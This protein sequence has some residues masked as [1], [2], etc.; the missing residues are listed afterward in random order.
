MYNFYFVYIQ[1]IHSPN[2]YH[3]RCIFSSTGS[4]TAQIIFH[5]YTSLL[6][7]IH[8]QHHSKFKIKTLQKH[9]IEVIIMYN[10]YQ[11]R[12]SSPADL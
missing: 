1:F 6:F 12:Y 4:I 2:H 3:N 10:A 5:P 9:P 11:I 7:I 8:P